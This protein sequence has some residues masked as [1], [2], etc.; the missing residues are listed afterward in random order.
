MVLICFNQ[1]TTLHQICTHS[2]AVS[3]LVGVIIALGRGQRGGEQV[4]VVTFALATDAATVPGLLLTRS[5]AA[6]YNL[7]EGEIQG[8]AD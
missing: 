7:K 4:V 3:L 8:W 2:A 1:P 5:L 6:V